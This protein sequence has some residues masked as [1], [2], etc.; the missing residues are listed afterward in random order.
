MTHQYDY[1]V[2]NQLLRGDPPFDALI[3]AALLKAASMNWAKLNMMWPDVSQFLEDV[4]AGEMTPAT[5]H[6]MPPC[7]CKTTCYRNDHPDQPPQR[8]CK[9]ADAVGLND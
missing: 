4:K 2:A 7:G 3:M 6:R 5:R 9:L 8:A 1:M